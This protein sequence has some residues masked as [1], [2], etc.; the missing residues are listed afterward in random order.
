MVELRGKYIRALAYR[1]EDKIFLEVTD[2]YDPAYESPIL[3]ITSEENLEKEAEELIEEF[4]K[5]IREV[6]RK[7]LRTS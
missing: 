4:S 2:L 5:I 1:H 7:I 6:V 3:L